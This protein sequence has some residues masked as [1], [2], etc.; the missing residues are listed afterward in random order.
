MQLLVPAALLWSLALGGK[1]EMQ[2]ALAFLPFYLLLY[3][4]EER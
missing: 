2:S 3:K 4:A 1:D